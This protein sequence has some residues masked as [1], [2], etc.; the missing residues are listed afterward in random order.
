MHA[1]IPCV[2]ITKDDANFMEASAKKNFCDKCCALNQNSLYSHTAQEKGFNIA[3][4]SN[5]DDESQCMLQMIYTM[6]SDLKETNKN[7]FVGI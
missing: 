3:F 1:C 5:V 7:L 6:L 2:K 4:L